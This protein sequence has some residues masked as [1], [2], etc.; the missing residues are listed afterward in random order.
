ML[1]DAGL[2]VSE[3]AAKCSAAYVSDVRMHLAELVDDGDAF[4]TIDDDHF[5]AV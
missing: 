3:I 1:S 2:A 4:S 5:G